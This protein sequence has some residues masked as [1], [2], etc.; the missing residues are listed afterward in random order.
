MFPGYVFAKFNLKRSLDVVHYAFGVA[1]VVHFGLF[2][3]VVPNETVETLRAL[4][5]E[6]EVREVAPALKVGQEVEVAAGSFAGFQGIVTRIMPAR[7]RVAVLLD[8]L[9]RQTTVELPLHGITHEGPR[10]ELEAA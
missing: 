4:I 10:F 8:F 2:W 7:D 1:H 9:G 6:E 3:P 5:G